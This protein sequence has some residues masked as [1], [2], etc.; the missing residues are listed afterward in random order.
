MQNKTKQKAKTPE[1]N[2]MNEW[3]NGN[4]LLYYEGILSFIHPF[5]Q[6]KYIQDT[7]NYET[8]K[9]NDSMTIIYGLFKPNQTNNDNQITKVAAHLS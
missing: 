4:L 2:G 3:I 6:T 5:I 8:E 1:T 9:K 7:N